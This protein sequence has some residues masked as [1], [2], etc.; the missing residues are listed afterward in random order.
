VVRAI[1]V[2]HECSHLAAP[3][4]PST[5]QAHPGLHDVLILSSRRTPVLPGVGL[6][7]GG[8]TPSLLTRPASPN[9]MPASSR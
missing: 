5:W 4:H 7:G 3:D 2:R 1:H 6:V 8:L 9:L